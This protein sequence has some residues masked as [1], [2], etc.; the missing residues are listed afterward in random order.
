M[1]AAASKSKLVK[2]VF[3]TFYV[4]IYMIRPL[5]CMPKKMTMGEIANIIVIICTNVLIYKFWGPYAV[6]Y[7]ILG[8]YLSVGLH[9]ASMH[10][11]A[12]HF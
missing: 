1:E 3:F 9:P 4:L 5:V 12:E 2:F 6:F 7:L 8:G 11:I 10:V